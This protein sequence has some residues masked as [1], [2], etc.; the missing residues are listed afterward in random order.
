LKNRLSAGFHDPMTLFD[1]TAPI[2]CVLHDAVC[3]N[4]V[5][6]TLTKWQPLSVCHNEVRVQPALPKIRSCEPDGRIGYVYTRHDRAV[7]RKPDQICSRSASHF[8]HTPASIFGERN[9]A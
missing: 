6:R 1:Q 2:R 4:E 7:L 3:V 8:K 5:E 9:Q